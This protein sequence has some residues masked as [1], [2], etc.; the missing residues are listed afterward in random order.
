MMDSYYP[1]STWLCLRRDVFE[2]LHRYKIE[3]GIPTWE[4][5]FENMLASA[6][7]DVVRS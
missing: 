2:D 6:R 1:N 7:E 3:R 5:A 4:Q